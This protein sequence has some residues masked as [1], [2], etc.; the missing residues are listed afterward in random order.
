MYSP[1]HAFAGLWCTCCFACVSCSPSGSLLRDPQTVQVGL[2]PAAASLPG[3]VDV[4]WEEGS[5]CVAVGGGPVAVLL[6]VPLIGQVVGVFKGTILMSG[7]R[8][9]EKLILTTEGEKDL[10]QSCDSSER[11]LEVRAPIET[12][13]S[14]AFLRRSSDSD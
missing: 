9:A 12:G 14:G 5:R 8:R 6:G 4:A 13:Y 1:R 3:R 2:L 7:C 11:Y 10:L